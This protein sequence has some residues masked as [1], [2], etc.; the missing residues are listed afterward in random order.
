MSRTLRPSLP[1]LPLPL[2]GTLSCSVF[3]SRGVAKRPR[4]RRPPAHPASHTSTWRAV[5]AG[6][7]QSAGPHTADVDVVGVALLAAEARRRRF[8]VVRE[9]AFF[10]HRASPLLRNRVH[11]LEK[12][13]RTIVRSVEKCKIVALAKRKLKAA[14]KRH[15][16]PVSALLNE[17]SN[18]VQLS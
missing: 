16:L 7:A 11:T 14:T 6:A 3:R 10:L 8:I 9:K 17:E 15:S 13:L 1:S 12:E 4:S 5:A 18:S 2:A